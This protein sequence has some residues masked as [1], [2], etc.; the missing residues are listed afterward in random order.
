ME[1][2]EVEE[3][4]L[5]GWTFDDSRRAYFRGNFA[6]RQ[7]RLPEVYVQRLRAALRREREENAKRIA[8]GK[9]AESYADQIH[10]LKKEVAMLREEMGHLLDNYGPSTCGACG[11]P[12][13]QCD[14]D[15][16]AHAHYAELAAGGR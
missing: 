8:W 1:E 14:M 16:V 7:W 3:A 5:E 2:K 9:V 15:C 4:D 13:A 10:E 11:Q 6:E 12:G